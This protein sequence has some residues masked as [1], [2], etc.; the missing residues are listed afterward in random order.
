MI[1]LIIFLI[2]FGAWFIPTLINLTILFIVHKKK[3][4]RKVTLE[5]FWD[6]QDETILMFSVLPIINIPGLIMLIGLL[7]WTPIWN[8]IKDVRI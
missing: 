4:K 3:V 5:E 6:D 8:R 1:V 7:I 2:V